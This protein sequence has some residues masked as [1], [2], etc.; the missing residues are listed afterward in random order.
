MSD[1]HGHLVGVL[2]RGRSRL[3]D[4]PLLAEDDEPA[5]ARASGPGPAAAPSPSPGGRRGGRDVA[6]PA[7]GDDLGARAR[8]PAAARRPARGWRWATTTPRP[9]WRVLLRAA[10]GRR[11]RDAGRPRGRSPARGWAM[12]LRTRACVAD[13]PEGDGREQVVHLDDDGDALG[14]EDADGSAASASVLGSCTTTTS[15]P[16]ASTSMTTDSPSGVRA[17]VVS[18]PCG[19]STSTPA[20]ASRTARAG[21]STR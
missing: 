19:T 20:P 12:P 14:L 17:I 15:A 3:L 7:D 4:V 2:L 18:S 11:R 21:S 16:R 6:G 5:R 10:A 9:C 1:I 13:V 8:R